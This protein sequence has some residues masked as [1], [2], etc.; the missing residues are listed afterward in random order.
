M[1]SW[2]VAE[3]EASVVGECRRCAAGCTCEGTVR[4]MGGSQKQA[5]RTHAL[6][7]R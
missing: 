2:P 1:G 5:R 7:T 3:D 4:S 6:R